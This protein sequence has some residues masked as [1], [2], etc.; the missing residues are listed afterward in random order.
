MMPGAGDDVNTTLPLILGIL[1][2]FCCWPAAIFIIIFAV[3][4]KGLK[5]QGQI[6]AARGKAK[7]ATIVGGIIVGLGAVFWIIYLILMVVGAAAG[8][9]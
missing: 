2:I 1:S 5:T 7:V 9:R 8:G 3:Q 4:A 6:E